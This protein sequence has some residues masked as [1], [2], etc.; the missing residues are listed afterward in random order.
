MTISRNGH[1]ATLLNN[2]DVLIVGGYTYAGPFPFGGFYETS[3]ASAELY[4]APSASSPPA[5]FSLAGHGAGQCIVWHAATRQFASPQRPAVAGEILSMYVIGLAEGGVIPP[6]VAVGGRLGE[7]LYF[8]DASGYPGYFQVNFRVPDGVS[9][10]A[11]V[12]LS[13]TYLGRPSN[14]ITIGVH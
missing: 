13:M 3:A 12:S 11:A 10:G 2:G 14:Q 8:G 4:H 7:I 6:Q 9:P 1:T 5:L